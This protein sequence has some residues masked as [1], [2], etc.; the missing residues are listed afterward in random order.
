MFSCLKGCYNL[1]QAWSLINFLIWLFSF[2]N[3]VCIAHISLWFCV[4]G[5]PIIMCISCAHCVLALLCVLC[6]LACAAPWLPP[7]PQALVAAGHRKCRPAPS[8]PTLQVHLILHRNAS[9]FQEPWHFHM[10]IKVAYI[11]PPAQVTSSPDFT[12]KCAYFMQC[13][14]FTYPAQVKRSPD[15][16]QT[17]GSVSLPA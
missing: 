11:L 17:C 1:I 3:T 13:L 5:V 16:S 15:F 4:Q 12:Q 9:K 14:N 10:Y 7:E 2:C 6:T 8:C